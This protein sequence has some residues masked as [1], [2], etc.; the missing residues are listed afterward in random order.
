ML[1]HSLALVDIGKAQADAHHAT[2]IVHHGDMVGLV[3]MLG[4][5]G[6]TEAPLPEGG[7]I[8]EREAKA[9]APLLQLAGRSQLLDLT[10]FD[11]L[12][13]PHACRPLRCRLIEGFDRA[14]RI[15]QDEPLGAGVED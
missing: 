14:V 4:S 7:T 9:L 2:G 11:E 1:L 6:V 15:G 3:P 12:P 10:A 8:P 13:S 5:A